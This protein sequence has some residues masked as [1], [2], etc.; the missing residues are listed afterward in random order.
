M[1][2]Q[3]L[4]EHLNPEEV[5]MISE[6][7]NEGKTLWIKGVFMQAEQKNRNGRIYPL[8]EMTNALGTINKYITENN[9][10]LGELDHPDNLIINQHNASHVITELYI[11]GNNVMGKAKIIDTPSG[12]IAKAIIE[13]G[14]RTGV[15]SRGAGTVNNQGIV[16]GFQIVT[17]DLVANPSAPGATPTSVYESLQTKQ[18]RKVMT[19]SEQLQEDASAQ[20]YFK[21]EMLKF[22]RE[23]LNYK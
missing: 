4:I 23:M 1:K 2:T 20:K 19:L 10:L 17:V 16:E 14:V 9:G 7:T 12:R 22:I 5:C 21:K 18:G 6:S 13:S 3:A 15:S 8:T 11:D